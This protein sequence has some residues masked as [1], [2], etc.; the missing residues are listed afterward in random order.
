MR[1]ITE[2]RLRELIEDSS[3]PVTMGYLIHECTELKPWQTIESAPKDRDVLWY[4][5]EFGKVIDFWGGIESNDPTH[6]Q[7]LPE[8]PK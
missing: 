8:D 5:P 3:C 4:L 2:E 7:E 1:G 6:W